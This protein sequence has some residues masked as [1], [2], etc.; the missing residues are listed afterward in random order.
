MIRGSFSLLQ[1]ADDS[2]FKTLMPIFFSLTVSSCANQGEL[3]AWDVVAGKRLWSIPNPGFWNGGTMATAG[4]LVFQGHADGTFNAFSSLKGDRLWSFDAQTGVLAPPITYSVEGK[5]YVT[6]LS[7]FGSSGALFGEV[8]AKFGW[9]ARTQP[10]R[11]LTFALGGTA[12][13]PPAPKL[14][15]LIPV[16][17]MT[18]KPDVALTARG[19]T[20]YYQRCAVCHGVDVIAAGLAPDLRASP[21]PSDANTFNAIVSDGA[22]VSQGMPSFG[23]IPEEDRAAVRQFLRTKA[24]EFAAANDKR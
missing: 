13:L 7:G 9:R 17:D 11:V 12:K 20:V 16:P 14:D 23:S 10:R 21:V 19:Q 1:I 22:L 18:F 24:R 15:P 8:V 2:L 5:Q 6:V 3:V 4:N